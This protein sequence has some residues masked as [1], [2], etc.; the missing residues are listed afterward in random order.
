MSLNVRLILLATTTSPPFVL[1]VRRT[2]QRKD[3]KEGQWKETRK[4]DNGSMQKLWLNWFGLVIIL[5]HNNLD[6]EQSAFCA[7]Q[8]DLFVNI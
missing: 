5:D 3:K 4:E 2:F 8:V 7:V 6:A 1:F